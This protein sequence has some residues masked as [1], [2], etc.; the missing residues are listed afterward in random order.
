MVLFLIAEV[1]RK[2]KTWSKIFQV[3][4]ISKDV[5]KMILPSIMFLLNS[6][7]VCCSLCEENRNTQFSQLNQGNKK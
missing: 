1:E 3:K 2:E 6:F 5:E 4:M 7:K